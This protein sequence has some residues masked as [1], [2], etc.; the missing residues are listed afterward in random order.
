MLITRSTPFLGTGVQCPPAAGAF[1]RG[2]AQAIYFKTHVHG[3]RLAR[4]GGCREPASC[5]V[6]HMPLA[7]S[8]C[9]GGDAPPPQTH[10]LNQVHMPKRPPNQISPLVQRRL[11][12][13]LLAMAAT[14]EVAS[15]GGHSGSGSPGANS[16]GS[17]SSQL[18]RHL[19]R[20]QQLAAASSDSQQ[21]EQP[22]AASS[23]SQRQRQRRRGRRPVADTG[24]G[25]QQEEAQPPASASDSQQQQRRRRVRR[26]AADTGDSQQQEEGQ[27]TASASGSPQLPQ[28]LPAPTKSGGQ[29]QAGED[30]APLTAFD[31]PADDDPGGGSAGSS[32][33]DRGEQGSGGSGHSGGDGGATDAGGDSSGDGQGSEGVV[34]TEEEQHKLTTAYIGRA[35]T[36]EEVEKQVHKRGRTMNHV[37]LCAALIQLPKVEGSM[38]RKRG[39]AQR[40][41]AL[42]A[43]HVGECSEWAL[44]NTIYAYAKVRCSNKRVLL[45]CIEHLQIRVQHSGSITPQ[46]ISSVMWALASLCEALGDAGWGLAAMEQHGAI[47]ATLLTQLIAQLGS[48]TPQNVSNVLLALAKLSLAGGAA[49]DAVAAA[50]QQ[51]G[52][53]VAEL[54]Q[55]LSSSLDIATPQAIANTL[56]ALAKLR[57]GGGAAVSAVDAAIQK[58][59]G[60]V[61]HVVGLFASGRL[62]LNDMEG[63]QLLRALDV[64]AAAGGPAAAAARRAVTDH[65]PWLAACW[66]GTMPD[67]L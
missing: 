43:P 30:Q 18:L 5:D 45:A 12:S 40:V 1:I 60:F 15:V 39:V 67:E 46:G 11:R 36:V 58:Q 63:R 4:R 41:L 38:Q 25:Q 50:L 17:S 49:A 16:S 34:L 3:S 2:A 42:L 37:C 55:Q 64:M 65:G 21:Q 59:P 44:A 48:A 19:R 22:A 54:L 66:Q 47:V 9:M 31:M 13:T 26:S 20:L 6:H 35:S 32:Q 29:L 27:P 33:L 7:S 62:G 14:S 61:S 24:D 23:D 10:T 28:Q 52:G 51:D 53:A 57:E 56:W 8:H